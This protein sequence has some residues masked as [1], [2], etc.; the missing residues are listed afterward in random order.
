MSSRGDSMRYNLVTQ[1]VCAECGTQ[2][3]LSYTVPKPPEDQPYD[4][5]AVR[6][7]RITGAAKVENKIAIHPCA[8]CYGEAIGPIEAIRNALKIIKEKE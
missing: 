4:P 2:L 8:K 3:S 5:F 1:F 7:D 6:D